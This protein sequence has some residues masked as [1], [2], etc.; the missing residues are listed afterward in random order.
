MA[1]PN[2]NQNAYKAALEIN[3]ELKRENDN[4]KEEIAKLTSS[5]IPI[6]FCKGSEYRLTKA[7]YMAKLA[8]LPDDL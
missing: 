4:L 7:E 8:E 5:K 1:N 3:R 2:N 6:S